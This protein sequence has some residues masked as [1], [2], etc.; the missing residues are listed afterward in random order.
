MP[1]YS[2][3]T[4]P[5]TK[6]SVFIKSNTFEEHR[7][8][9]LDCCDTYTHVWKQSQMKAAIFCT[10]VVAT[11]LCCVLASV[12]VA[13]IFAVAAVTYFRFAPANINP[14]AYER[15]AR[16]FLKAWHN[17]IGRSIT[18]PDAQILTSER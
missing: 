13:G 8:R 17:E 2:K 15:L 11:I 9:L 5:L 12:I 18:A 7:R 14:V 1:Y 3:V 10:P 4:S 16:A 6:E